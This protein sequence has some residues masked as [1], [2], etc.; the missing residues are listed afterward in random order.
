MGVTELS[1]MGAKGTAFFEERNNISQFIMLF[2]LNLR[3]EVNALFA[4]EA[5]IIRS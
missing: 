3:G 2:F 1:S 5:S 4:P